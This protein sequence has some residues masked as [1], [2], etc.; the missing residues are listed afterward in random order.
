MRKLNHSTAKRTN[1]FIDMD[2]DCT[3]GVQN[4]SFTSS[5]EDTT[6][7]GKSTKS[8]SLFLAVPGRN[9]IYLDKYKGA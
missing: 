2:I 6:T 4:D 9:H 3:A 8:F 7:K 5:A 1:K